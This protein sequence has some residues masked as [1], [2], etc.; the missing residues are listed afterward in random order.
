MEGI[1]EIKAALDKATDDVRELMDTQKGEIKR[2]GKSQESTDEKL[3]EHEQKLATL[4]GSLQKA[5]E[6]LDEFEVKLGRNG[7]LIR[8]ASDEE[9]KSL[10]SRFIDDEGVKSF[11]DELGS[12]TKFSKGLDIKGGFSTY[13]DASDASMLLKA[14]LTTDPSSVG[15]ALDEWR[16]SGIFAAPFRTPRI[17]S[18][19]PVNRVGSGVGAIEYVEETEFSM[20]W[21]YLTVAAT[22]GVTT[23]LEVQ[24]ANGFKV[25][26][27][28]TIGKGTA[29]EE[30][31]TV[32]SKDVDAKTITLTAAVTQTHSPGEGS[33]NGTVTA[34]EYEFTPEGVFKPTADF[35]LDDA[36]AKIHTLAT[37]I[38]A[39]RQALDD[40]EMLRAHIDSRLM[41]SL[42]LS[43]EKMILYGDGSNT[44]LQGFLT[45]P[46]RQEFEWS[47]SPAGTT[48]MDAVLRM[49]TLAALSNYPT[50]GI[51]C[52]PLFWQEVVLAKDANGRYLNDQVMGGNALSP[53]L[54]GL[55]VIR[56]TAINP[57]D[58]LTGGFALGAAL[59]DREQGTIAVS[60][61]HANFFMENK[62]AI[63]AEERVALTTYRPEAFVHG[64]FAASPPAP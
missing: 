4:S 57:T 47:T 41:E 50:S 34:T 22:A 35:K 36:S 3:N 30:V 32:A 21:T 63:R 60:D 53:T 19:L 13:R 8:S 9:I 24:N 38:F 61:Q 6:K 12:G 16:V 18:L 40:V 44:Q 11:L 59:W 10:G 54:W 17:R 39:T 25:G 20:I 23:V 15:A 62:I 5:Q 56:T 14:L 64:D 55:P 29:Q 42:A 49:I 51:V 27:K 43:E 26:S 31:V 37:A 1:E 58:V 46:R 28:V 48:R 52:H 45:N 33:A 7:K 2:I